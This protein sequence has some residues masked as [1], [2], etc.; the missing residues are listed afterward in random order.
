MSAAGRGKVMRC[1]VHEAGSVS[2]S[3][4]AAQ[5]AAASFC[6]RR[7]C[8]AKPTRSMDVACLVARDLFVV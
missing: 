4:T 3:A 5:G 1:E 7:S 8:A 2:S 6:T